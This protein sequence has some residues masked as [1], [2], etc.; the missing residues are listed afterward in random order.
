MDCRCA[1]GCTE[2]LIE[3]AATI[4]V[5]ETAIAIRRGYAEAI[6]SRSKG[7]LRVLVDEDGVGTSTW[8]CRTRPMR[9]TCSPRRITCPF[10]FGRSWT[11]TPPIG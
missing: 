6:A 2:A 7:T 11:S 1:D 5:S 9:G 8:T 4:D 10:S 3:P